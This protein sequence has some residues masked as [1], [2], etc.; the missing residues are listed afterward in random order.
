ML[1]E[2][3]PRYKKVKCNPHLIISVRSTVKILYNK[4][5]TASYSNYM[6]CCCE[7]R[8]VYIFHLSSFRNLKHSDQ[9][10]SNTPETKLIYCRH[11]KTNKSRN[12][13]NEHERFRKSFNIEQVEW[14]AVKK[15]QY[16]NQRHFPAKNRIRTSGGLRNILHGKGISSE[17]QTT[18][19]C[20]SPYFVFPLAYFWLIPF[21]RGDCLERK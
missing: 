15:N 7:F 18:N 14:T 17:I 3:F 16:Y 13:V 12:S 19:S 4:V 11:N 2:H 8:T 20:K 5:F 9:I 10:I 1:K 6:F 21:K